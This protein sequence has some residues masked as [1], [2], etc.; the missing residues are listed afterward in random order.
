MYDITGSDFLGSPPG[1]H[2]NTQ[3][4]RKPL[5]TLFQFQ[6]IVWN[7]EITEKFPSSIIHCFQQPCAFSPLLWG[8]SQPGY[9]VCS[10]KPQ[11]Q[12]LT[13]C[14]LVT[15]KNE[16]EWLTTTNCVCIAWDCM[17][18]N[19]TSTLQ[20]SHKKRAVLV[21]ISAICHFFHIYRPLTR[22]STWLETYS[23]CRC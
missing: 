11:R 7:Q 4:Y 15:S 1:Q 9:S 18:L 22:S 21:V 20:V 16:A 19:C 3:V 23:K 5:A 14:G 12:K 13:W 2:A 17:T 6:D 8:Y 10:I